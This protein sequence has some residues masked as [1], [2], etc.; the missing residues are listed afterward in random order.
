MEKSKK[1]ERPKISIQKGKIETK[2]LKM[3]KE[4]WEH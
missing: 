4:K 3:R 2:E 1:N